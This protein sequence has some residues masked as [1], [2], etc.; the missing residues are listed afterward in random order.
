[1]E[2]KIS[3]ITPGDQVVDFTLP[4]YLYRSKDGFANFPTNLQT[5]KAIRQDGE[6]LIGQNL[7]PRDL[8]IT[9]IINGNTRQEVLV[10]RRNLIRMFNSKLGKGRIRWTRDDGI[11]EI[12]AV[13][14]GELDFPN[15]RSGGKLHQ[16]VVINLL[17]PDPRWY[18]PDPVITTV[19][20][21]AT[22]NNSGDLAT[23][24]KISFNGPATGP[25]SFENKTT[26]EKITVNKDLAEGETLVINSKY[27]SKEISI[28]GVN[29]FAFIDPSSDFPFLAQ[30]NNEIIVSHPAEVEFYN[31]FLGI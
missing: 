4:E 12:N 2:E 31:R 14:N 10:R 27:G 16:A 20:N 29:N 21:S 28:N 11:Y 8:S 9:L 24:L 23:P 17:A 5:V 15:S 7:E 3:W 30:G 18:D 22:V 6:T 26:G 1:M 19:T 25:V 13:C